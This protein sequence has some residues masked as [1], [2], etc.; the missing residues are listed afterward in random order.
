MS[1]RELNKWIPA[2]HAGFGV[3]VV[4]PHTWRGRLILVQS[5]MDQKRFKLRHAC[6]SLDLELLRSVSDWRPKMARKLAELRRFV[7]NTEPTA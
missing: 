6:I 4:A 2:P 1:A 3:T 7:R 5:V